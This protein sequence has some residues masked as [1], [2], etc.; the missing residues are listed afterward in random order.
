MANG[1]T[2]NGQLSRRAERHGSM[3][4]LTE[5][6]KR[7]GGHWTSLTQSLSEAPKESED[8]ATPTPDPPPPAPFPVSSQARLSGRP[9]PAWL[10][11]QRHTSSQGQAQMW[12]HLQVFSP[13]QVCI[14]WRGGGHIYWLTPPKIA[15]QLLGSTPVMA[16]THTHTHCHWLITPH[17]HMLTHS[18]APIH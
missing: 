18:R 8:P 16:H 3:H 11:A 12:N 2:T 10:E 1:W 5:R 17:S 14:E 13:E 7:A 9:T 15:P 4:G 6:Q